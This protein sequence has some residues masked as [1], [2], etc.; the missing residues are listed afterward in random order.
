MR[1]LSSSYTF[2]YKRVFPLLWCGFLLI[3]FSMQFLAGR[4]ARIPDQ[5]TDVLP[6]LLM[7]VFMLGVGFF[8]YR[9]LIQDLVDE[10][11]LD[12]DWLIVKN[13][14]E[15]RRVALSD[16]M[17]INATTM[18]NPRRI[19]VML[20]TDSCYGRSF[21]FMPASPRRFLSAFNPDPIATDLIERV[22]AL[23]GAAR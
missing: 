14:D 1:R 3:A 6:F 2:F 23:R 9:K 16:V 8:I 12:G 10:V 17:N 19:T 15:Q 5:T 20:R 13:R 7:P 4:H 11:W 18:T 21:S 22:D